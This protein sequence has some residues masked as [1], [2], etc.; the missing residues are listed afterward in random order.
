MVMGITLLVIVV[1]IISIY[2]FIELK[3]FRHKMFAIFLIALIL[4]VYLTAM[5]VFKGKDVNLKTVPGSI[6]AVK[7]YFNWLFSIFGNLKTITANAIHMDW[8]TNKTVS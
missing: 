6:D 1:L 2:V 5:Y 3:R 7:I 8:G 4:F